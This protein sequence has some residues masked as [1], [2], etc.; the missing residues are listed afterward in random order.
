MDYLILGLAIGEDPYMGIYTKVNLIDKKFILINLLI[1]KNIYQ[2]L[3]AYLMIF[4]V[5]IYLRKP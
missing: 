2:L 3:S 4:E 1:D 5:N